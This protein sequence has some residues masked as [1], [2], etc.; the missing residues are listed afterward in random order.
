MMLSGLVLIAVGTLL[1]VAEP[2][3]DWK[4]LYGFC[5]IVVGAFVCV[6]AVWL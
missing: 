4:V 3:R 6:T 2:V 1:A 5:L